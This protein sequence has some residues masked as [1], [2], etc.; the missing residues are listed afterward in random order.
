MAARVE[1]SA[2]ACVELA[3]TATNPDIRPAIV[4]KDPKYA[5]TATKPVISPEIVLNPPR[6]NL[7]TVAEK[8]DISPGIVLSKM[9]LLLLKAVECAVVAPI[10]TNAARLDILHAIV[11]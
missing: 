7:A 5:I 9:D 6:A 3:T 10:A 4:P 11:P 8:P 2:V 1:D